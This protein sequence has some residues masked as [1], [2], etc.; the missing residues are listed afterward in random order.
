MLFQTF[1]TK[2]TI[3]KKFFQKFLKKEQKT[4]EKVLQNGLY[5]NLL[6]LPTDRFFICFS[7]QVYDF[8]QKKLSVG[9]FSVPLKI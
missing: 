6:N 5:K 3:L 2:N 9:N 7:K 8:T 1:F 4:P